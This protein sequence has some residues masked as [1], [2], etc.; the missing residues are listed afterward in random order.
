MEEIQKVD[1]VVVVETVKEN[2]SSKKK[3]PLPLIAMCAGVLL[4][5]GA[6]LFTRG[7]IVAA[8]VN[9]SQISRLSVIQEL[10]KTAGKAT[11]ETLINK[12]LVESELNKLALTVDVTEVSKR[13]AEL[14]AQIT[15][16]GGTLEEVL[17]SEGM[18]LERLEKQI[19]TTL[20]LEQVLKDKTSVTAEEVDAFI[21]TGGTPLPTGSE[22]DAIKEQVKNQLQQQ[23]F[24]TEAQKWIAEVTAAAKIKYYVTY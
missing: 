8:T 24:Q 5:A 6:F 19:E 15:A 10:E 14:E 2:S 17:V 1:E 13:I 21:K 3:V 20:Q 12:K 9:G 18:T 16:Q 11:L 7:Y 23:K 4:V 22:A